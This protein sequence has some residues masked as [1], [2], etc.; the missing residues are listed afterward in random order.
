MKVIIDLIDNNNIGCI[1]KSKYH[2]FSLENYQQQCGFLFLGQFIEHY[3]DIS[4]DKE[5]LNIIINILRN[6]FIFLKN[7]NFAA[8]KE[9]LLCINIL[10]NKLKKGF[11]IYAKELLNNIYIF[12]KILLNSSSSLKTKNNDYIDIKI[13]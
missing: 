3:N 10:I 8:K 2:D 4:N 12:D 1:F 11:S 6:H 9:Y 13:Y 7:K 5:T